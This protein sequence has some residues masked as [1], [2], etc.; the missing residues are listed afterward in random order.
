MIV[1]VKRGVARDSL[2]TKPPSQPQGLVTN[3]TSSSSGTR[4]QSQ[5]PDSKGRVTTPVHSAQPRRYLGLLS[6]RL[7]RPERP[8]VAAES[9]GKVAVDHGNVTDGGRQ[10]IVC[11]TRKAEA[12]KS[13]QVVLSDYAVCHRAQ[14]LYPVVLRGTYQSSYRDGYCIHQTCSPLIPLTLACCDMH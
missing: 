14:L 10:G 1:T 13:P 4:Q 8:I 7:S 2:P 3:P 6:P 5:P 9:S 11:T 12:M